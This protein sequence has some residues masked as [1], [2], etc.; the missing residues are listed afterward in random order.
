MIL[1]F[2]YLSS[3]YLVSCGSQTN[4]DDPDSETLFTEFNNTRKECRFL[5]QHCLWYTHQS[6]IKYQMLSL[7]FFFFLFSFCCR[8]PPQFRE[9][10]CKVQI[11]D[12]LLDNFLQLTRN[13]SRIPRTAE[14]KLDV[15]RCC[16]T[17]HILFNANC[18]Q[19]SF[20]TGKETREQVT[21]L[22]SVLYEQSVF[23]FK[24]SPFNFQ[25]S[26]VGN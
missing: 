18:V 6:T 22:A 15:R 8:M 21:Y 17:M 7:D 24:C 12:S 26:S 20:L 19:V 2:S 25:L 4:E 13:H 16:N 1:L 3:N 11:E 10:S 23:K 5:S 9:E 14:E